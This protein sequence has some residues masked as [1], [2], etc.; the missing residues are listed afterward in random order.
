MTQLVM[1][2]ILGESQHAD[3][4]AFEDPQA[5]TLQPDEFRLEPVSAKPHPRSAEATER[6]LASLRE[7][8]AVKET[9]ANVT[10]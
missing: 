5:F 3:Q 2:D 7:I 10:A 4:Q 9:R 6:R 1:W 8:A